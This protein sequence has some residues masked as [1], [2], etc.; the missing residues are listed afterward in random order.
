MIGWMGTAGRFFS[1]ALIGESMI[2]GA[3]GFLKLFLKMAKML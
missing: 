3:K 1:A 2:T